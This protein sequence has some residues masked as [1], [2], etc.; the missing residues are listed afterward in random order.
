M[1]RKTQIQSIGIKVPQVL[2]FE[3]RRFNMAMKVMMIGFS[4]S[5]KTSYMGGMYSMLN[6]QSC[7]GFSLR[8]HD[9][10]AHENFL[11]IGAN[12]SKG[13]YPKGTDILEEYKFSLIHNGERLLDFDWH[14]Y[15]GGVLNMSDGPEFDRVISM[16]V[17]SE[18]LVV[19]LD[20]PMFC[21]E[22][23]RKTI[24]VMN[25]IMSL[26]QNVTSKVRSDVNF[27]ISFVLTKLDCFTE[28]MK[29]TETV[30]WQRFLRIKEIIGE[31]KN[32]RGLSTATV[33]GAEGCLNIEYPFLLSMYFAMLKKA[34]EMIAQYNAKIDSANWNAEKRSL[35]NEW[36]TGISN[37]F[38]GEQKLSNYDI[39]CKEI[40]EAEEMKEKFSALVEGP[41]KKV[42]AYLRS[43]AQR[44]DTHLDLF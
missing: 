33:V 1:R 32:V 29:T 22:R 43:E 35:I 18:A 41:L 11:R 36:A 38:T 30:G 39:A 34:N 25:R 10:K 8:A 7:V 14:D 20:L 2:V 28:E 40:R 9:E 19:F 42:E 37:F 24:G 31:S 5:G 6:Q 23:D 12:L 21:P 17:E 4:G 16:I 13:I 27:P 44:E 3:D 15:R 26:I